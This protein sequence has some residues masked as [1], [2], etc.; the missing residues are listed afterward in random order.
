MAAHAGTHKRGGNDPIRLDDL[1]EPEDNVDLDANTLRHGLLPKLSGN[2]SDVLKGDGTFGSGG[3]GAPTSAHYVTTQAESGLSAEFNLGGLTTGL[4]KHSVSAGVSTPAT[5]AA[6]T[7]YVAP[8]AVT[9]SGLTQATARLLG[10]TTAS[11]GAIE[12]ISVG[13]GLTLSSGSLSAPG[14]AFHGVKAYH[15]TTQSLTANTPTALNL[16]S[17]EYDTDT[18]HDTSTAN[19][20][21]TVPSDG[22]YRLTGMIYCGSNVYVLGLFKKNGTTFLRSSSLGA[23][24][25]TSGRIAWSTSVFLSTNDYVELFGFINSNASVGDATNAEQQTMF[26]LELMGT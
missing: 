24:N 8:G 26:A 18:Y 6:A 21:L 22:Y 2:G 16:N 15:N 13:S 23:S 20:R 19:T 11:A 14:N 7:D 3:S 25:G 4:L 12:E 17:E 10:R 9:T 5:A 1:A